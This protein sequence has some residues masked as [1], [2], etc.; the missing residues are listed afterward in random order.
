MIGVLGQV[1]TGPDAWVS[2]EH[3]SAKAFTPIPGKGLGPLFPGSVGHWWA[4]VLPRG[5][6]QGNPSRQRAVLCRRGS[7]EPSAACTHTT[8]D[9]QAMIASPWCGLTPLLTG[10]VRAQPRV[11]VGRPE[12][13]V[14]SDPENGQPGLGTGVQA[15]EDPPH[16][17]RDPGL[18]IQSNSEHHG[19]RPRPPHPPA[20]AAP[21]KLQGSPPTAAPRHTPS[22]RPEPQRVPGSLRKLDGNGV[23]ASSSPSSSLPSFFLSLPLKLLISNLN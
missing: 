15:S 1:N 11:C 3:Q 2:P 4:E 13:N 8:R 20:E 21:P 22:P 23:T 6:A 18:C 10:H 19:P 14:L 5:A 7:C 9:G 16:P 17:P 12:S